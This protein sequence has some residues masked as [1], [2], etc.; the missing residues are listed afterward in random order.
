M[1]TLFIK[2]W[3]GMAQNQLPDWPLQAEEYVVCEFSVF[4][5]KLGT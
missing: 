5:C 1:P 3:K 4:R 2:M